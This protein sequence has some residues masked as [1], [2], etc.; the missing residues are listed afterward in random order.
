MYDLIGFGEHIREIRSNLNLTQI[1]VAKMAGFQRDTLR[2][3]ETGQSIP[4]IETL[5]RLSLIYGQD[6]YILFG[7]HRLTIDNYITQRMYFISKDFRNFNYEKIEI[8]IEAFKLAFSDS[9]YL[10]DA[11]QK[12]KTIQYTTYL[13][14]LANIRSLLHDKSRALLSRLMESLYLSSGYP[15][16]E[17]NKFDKLEI[18]ILILLGTLYRTKDELHSTI[19]FFDLALKAV[20]ARYKEDPDF[21]YFYVLIQLNRMTFYHRLDHHQMIKSIYEESLK[22]ID[23]KIGMN[24]LFAFLVRSGINKHML[25]EPHL[26]GF[27]QTALQLIKDCGDQPKYDVEL[28]NLREKY[29]FLNLDLIYDSE[30]SNLSENQT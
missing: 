26:D 4:K 13:E 25:K 27:V 6:L 12:K 15:Q 22:V 23:Q 9:S 17:E 19:D 2:R 7:H 21:L 28:K 5:D 29:D 18:R 3:L 30:T 20:T 11:Y 24:N 10:G 16:K 8:E 14:A 1:E